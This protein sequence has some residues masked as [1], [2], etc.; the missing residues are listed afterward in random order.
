MS[1]DKTV[2]S[3]KADIFTLRLQCTVDSTI[4]TKPQTLFSKIWSPLM[5]ALR[6]FKF[7][8]STIKQI[9]DELNNH[10]TGVLNTEVN[11]RVK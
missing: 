7:S 1:K 5:G 4:F 11:I 9:E 2:T 3:K 8:P 10:V 6:G